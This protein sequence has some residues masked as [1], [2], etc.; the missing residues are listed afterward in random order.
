MAL[1]FRVHIVLHRAPCRGNMAV[2]ELLVRH[3]TDMNASRTR[4]S[5]VGNRG[6]TRHSII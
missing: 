2:I 4:D 1:L 6:N 5:V 3:G